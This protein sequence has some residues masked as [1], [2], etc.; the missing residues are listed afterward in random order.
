MKGVLR[1]KFIAIKAYI[2]KS[3][4]PQIN[5]PMMNFKESKNEEQADKKNVWRKT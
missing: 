5:N 4:R 3:D 1:R 2:K